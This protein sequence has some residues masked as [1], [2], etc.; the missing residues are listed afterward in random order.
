MGIYLFDYEE[1]TG[2]KQ[3][4]LLI[5]ETRGRSKICSNVIM[6]RLSLGQEL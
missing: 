4:F 5:Y 3:H 6:I 2:H 1:V